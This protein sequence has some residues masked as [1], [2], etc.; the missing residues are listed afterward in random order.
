MY[1]I[2]EINL[3]IDY[4]PRLRLLNIINAESNIF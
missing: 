3:N 1:K 4:Q 2:K